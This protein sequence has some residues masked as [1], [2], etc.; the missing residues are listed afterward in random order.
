[1]FEIVAHC[2]QLPV[3]RSR[4]LYSTPR[5]IRSSNRPLVPQEI[6]PSKTARPPVPLQPAR[7]TNPEQAAHNERGIR[8]HRAAC[9]SVVGVVDV[10]RNL[11]CQRAH[12]SPDAPFDDGRGEH[13]RPRRPA[14]YRPHRAAEPGDSVRDAVV[15]V[16]TTIILMTS[17]RADVGGCTAE[18]RGSAIALPLDR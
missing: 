13:E 5:K 11:F 3:M 15:I 10:F 9:V 8:H 17:G 6:V 4:Q 16:A 12:R 7:F 2:R 1:M 14:S 18:V